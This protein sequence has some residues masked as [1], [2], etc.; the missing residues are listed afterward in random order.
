MRSSRKHISLIL[1]VIHTKFS[2]DISNNLIFILFADAATVTL[3]GEN[4]PP[5]TSELNNELNLLNVWATQNRLIINTDKTDF[6]L[7]SNRPENNND[8]RLKIG[9][10]KLTL[11]TNYN[12]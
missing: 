10:N 9:Q 7:F 1:F 3:T 4:H 11:T 8:I 5:L 6:M 12:F 2:F